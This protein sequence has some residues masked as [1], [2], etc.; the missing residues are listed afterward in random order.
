MNRVF[1]NVG[2]SLIWVFLTLAM[3]YALPNEVRAQVKKR[4]VSVSFK[5]KDLASILDFISAQTDHTIMY[6]NDVKSYPKTVTVS[7]DNVAPVKAVQE[8]LAGSPFTYKVEGK[9]ITVYRLQSGQPAVGKATKEVSGV[10]KEVNGDPLPYVTIQLKGTKQGCRSNIDGVFKLPVTA[11]KGE[12]IITS[13]GFEAQTVKYSVGTPLKI[14]MKES[15]NTLGEVSVIAYGERNTRE[16][17]G[18]ISSVKGEKLQ[19]VPTPSIETL[20]QGQMSGVEVSNLSGSP[21]GGGTNIVIRGHSSLNVQGVNNGSPLFVIDGVPVRS[22]ASSE[23]AGINPLASLDPTTIESV[24]VLKDAAS[25]ILY[26]SRAG[27]GVILITTKKGKVGKNEFNV[28][29]SQ[30]Y[31]WLPV[32]PLQV[33]GKGERDFRLLQAKRSRTANYDWDTELITV[34]QNHNDSYGWDP[35]PNFGGYY[36]YL[37]RNGALLNEDYRLPLIAQDSLNTFYNNRT[38]WYDYAFQ[39]GKVTKADLTALGG[40]ENLRYM[41]NAGF[42]DETGIMLNSKF[43]RAT[44]GSNIDVKLTPKIEAFA[45]VNLAYMKKA[46]GD[47]GR[48][49]G[50]TIDPKQT[51]TLFPGKGSIAEEIAVRQLRDVIEKNANYNVRLNIGGQYKILRGLTLS[52]S[53]AVNHY[54][55]R[56]N[57]FTPNYLNANGLTSSQARVIGMTSIQNENILNYNLNI[58]DTHH[59]DILGGVTFNAEMLEKFSGSA[60]GGPTN[61]I[62]YI[63]DGWPQSRIDEAGNFEALQ[64]VT[65]DFEEQKM[66]SYLGRMSYNYKKKY[67]LDLSLRSDGSSVFGSDVRWGIFPAAAL[68]WAFSYEPFMKDFWWLSFGKLRASWGRSGQKFQSAYLA[69]GIM[70]EHNTFFGEVGLQPGTLANSRLTWE[71]S[72]QYDFGLDLDLLNYRLKVKL[73]YYYKYS[74]ALLMQVPV[75]GDVCLLDEKWDNSSAISNEGIELEVRGDIFRDKPFNWTVDFNISR[76]WNMFRESYGN[77]DLADKV[78]GRPIHGIYTYKDEGIVQD[79]SEIP[80]Y[81]DQQGN[82]RPLLIPDENHPLRVGGRKIKDQNGDGRINAKDIFYAG[83]TIPLAYGGITNTFSWK[84]FTL[85]VLFNYSLSRKVM[86]MVKAAAFNFDKGFGTLM[87]DPSRYIFWEQKGDRADYPSLEFSDSGYIGQFDGDI[88]SNIEN[89][90]FVRLKQLVLSYAM[91]KPFVQKFGFK[92]A[93]VYLSGENLLLLSNYSGIDPEIIDP[94]SGKDDGKSYPLN[95]KITVGMTLKF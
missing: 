68:G 19:D 17:V 36:D 32:T 20:L 78:L 21:G 71:K 66:M 74:S 70:Q 12:L 89:V 61:R 76:N 29:V 11:D 41:L 95:R 79:E 40:T 56:S 82:R 77:I 25:A 34:P 92:D 62:Y 83:S 59:F 65:T 73:D 67:L 10:I 69:H 80:Q 38:N 23:T 86:N 60:Y 51:S 13:V 90:S 64:K 48:A 72:D 63:G 31:S 58:R 7:F 16:I 54:L 4:V 35:N 18:S 81:Y 88:A 85:S 91:P 45:R 42:Y 46:G 33:I 24:E 84:G 43:S 53:A 14:V 15:V 5:E 75:P 22:D 94:Y 47:Q 26:G 8:I 39:V 50:L 9:K 37:W 6:D 93:R 55:T 28:N 1:V 3:G 87:D 57:V 30:S 44:F 52:S 27:N 2:R 49:Q